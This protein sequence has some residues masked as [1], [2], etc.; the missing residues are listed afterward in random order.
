LCLLLTTYKSRWLRK[1]MVT[2]AMFPYAPSGITGILTYLPNIFFCHKYQNQL[3]HSLTI[4]L[5]CMNYSCRLLMLFRRVMVFY[6]IICV[7]KFHSGQKQFFPKIKVITACSS[8]PYLKF[9]LGF[10]LFRFTSFWPLVKPCFQGLNIT[11]SP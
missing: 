1:N 7:I 2:N 4:L 10:Y 8:S 3:K 11:F 9:I 6:C 5:C